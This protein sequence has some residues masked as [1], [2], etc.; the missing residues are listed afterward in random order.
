M[1]K[2]KSPMVA[3]A[4]NI[5]ITNNVVNKN[6]LRFLNLPYIL[7]WVI[8]YAWVIAFTT[9][10]T[11][12]P[13]TEYV[14][15]TD[16]RSIIHAINLMSSAFFIFLIPKKYYV[17]T[18]RIGALFI[19]VGMGI[20]LLI[21]DTSIQL[22]A[23]VGIGVAL[24]CVNISILIPFV[25]VLNNTEK[26]YS[27][28]GSY[29]L[30]NLILL[31]QLWGVGY[32]LFGMKEELLSLGILTVSL[33]AT[34]LFR[35]DRVDHLSDN[36]EENPPELKQRV[37]LTLAVS[38]AFA[39]LCKGA[40]KGML[41]LSAE[42]YGNYLHGWYYIGGLIGCLVYIII[43][44]F[45]KK[46]YIWLWNITFGCIAFGT[47]CYAFSA[48]VPAMAMIFSILLGIGNTIGMIHVYY[49]LGVV[50]KKYNSMHYLRLSILFIGICGGV[51]GVVVG[52]LVNR[53]DSLSLSIAVSVLSSIF[54]ILFL[55]ISPM[56]TQ[57]RYY[58]DW[59]KD[60]ELAEI[61]NKPYDLFQRYHLSKRE[62]EVCKLL[63]EGYTLRQI[64]AILSIAYSTVNT[65]CTSTYRKLKINSRTELLILFKD[66][67][68][69]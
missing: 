47:L 33:S 53:M 38:C 4:E 6:T 10:W 11:A 66:Y 25:F 17:K 55:A 61:D 50:G 35:R 24:G 69:E 58:N 67:D 63:L 9:W 27:V 59:A 8:Y 15:G 30:V 1:L 23:A 7:I 41:N 36:K 31:N 22:L 14:F 37:F 44:A 54:M 65:Y 60:S 26:L 43:Y 56:L 64:S 12:S 39:I 40:S 42:A 32:R 62:T 18:A 5:R 48:Q 21:P 51:A 29:I 68:K 13:I 34:L 46:A 45:R 20:Y 2:L 57:T 49:I 16:I 28:V 19:I 3:T 52:N